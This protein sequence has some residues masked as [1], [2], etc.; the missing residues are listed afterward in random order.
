MNFFDK[1]PTIPYDITRGTFPNY[2]EV[3][4]IFFRLAIVKEAINNISAYYE[5]TIRDGDTPEILAEKIYGDAEAHW[6]ILMANDI[7]DPQYDWPLDKPSFLNYIKNKYDLISLAKTQTHHYEKVIR[8]EES[9]TGIITET[10]FQIDLRSQVEDIEAMGV[11]YESYEG[12]ADEQYVEVFD[13]G[14]G[15]TVVQTTF[16]DRIT[17]WDWEMQQ[18]ENKRQIKIIKKEY[19]GQIL[20]EFDELIKHSDTPFLRRFTQ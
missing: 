8:R 6:V 2:E 18:N 14:N 16:R 13:I 7:V 20:S 9:R 15:S 17:N 10:R 1:F 4:N 11:P 3:T 5:Y 19:Y 12:T